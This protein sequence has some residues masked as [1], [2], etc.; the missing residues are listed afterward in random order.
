MSHV[1]RGVFIYNVRS[2]GEKMKTL[3]KTLIVIPMLVFILACQAVTRPIEQVQDT[4]GTAAAYATQAGEVV[5]QVS[6][7]ATE[8]APFETLIPDPSAMPEFPSGNPFDPQ[9]PP[10]SEWKGIPVMPQAIAGEESQGMYVFKID[11]ASQEIQDFYNAQLPDLGWE[12]TVSLPM[13]GTAILLFTKGN[14]VLS[15]TIMP[16]ESDGTIVMIT[17]Q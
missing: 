9:S 6:G 4:A 16:A 10:L 13:E 17:L 1:R 8:F 7:L 11:A 3:R 15:I 2:K 14:Q 12:T 5:T